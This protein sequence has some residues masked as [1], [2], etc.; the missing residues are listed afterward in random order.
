MRA[1]SRR[2]SRAASLRS[3]SPG[4]ST[5]APPPRKN[6]DVTTVSP[7]A[8]RRITIAAQGY[9][10]RSRAGTAR[11]VEGAI[12]RLSCVQLDSISAVERSHR[13]AL[14]SRVG[15]YL[16]G[17]VGRLLASGRVFEYWA[18]E[19]CLLPIEDW[20]LFAAQ[21]QQGGRGWYGDVGDTH[22]HL[23]EEIL[24]EIRERGRLGSRHFEGT[25]EG[26]M[27]NWKPAKAML[28]RLWNHG[29]LVIAG[30]QGFQRLYDLPERVIPRA[31]AR[32][33]RSRRQRAA[34]RAGPEGGRGPRRP[35]RG[36]CG[37]ALATEGRRGPHPPGRRCPHRRRT[38]PTPLGRRRWTGRP[39]PQRR[40]SRAGCAD[41]R[42][43]ALPVRQSA[44]GSAVRRDASS[45]STT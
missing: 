2:F 30:R 29:D 7:I 42:R 28:D 44:L 21:M 18:H 15:A 32:S 37:R 1:A 8:L 33:T 40:R 25:S 41:G 3:R 23:A 35:D 11:E 10:S 31:V 9:A 5:P 14:A 19:A 6:A 17:T 38:A 27:W 45:A 39:R 12:R 22:P 20:P 4:R 16:P 36:G 43:A 26:G 34:S 13:I 24:A